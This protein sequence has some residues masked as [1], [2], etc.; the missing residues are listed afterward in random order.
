MY[1]YIERDDL[2]PIFHKVVPG[3]TLYNIANTYN[4]TVNDI[5]HGNPN[6]VSINLH[7]GEVLTIFPRTE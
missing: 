2:E 5:L 3:D 6:I 1:E 7:V 4:T